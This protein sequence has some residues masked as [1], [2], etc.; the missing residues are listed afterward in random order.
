MRRDFRH[1]L[2]RAV[3]QA[4]EEGWRTADIAAGKESIGTQ[5]MGDIVCRLIETA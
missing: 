2:E 5:Q 4:L 3:Q 1:V